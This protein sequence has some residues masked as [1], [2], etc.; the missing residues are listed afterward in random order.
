MKTNRVIIAGSRT[1]PE[2][3]K[4]LKQSVSLILN[5]IDKNDLE[6]VSGGAKGADK[7]GENWANNRNVPVKIFPADWDTWGKSAG[8][9]RNK[10]MAQYANH[11][12]AIVDLE[13]ESRGTRHM[14]DL[15]HR[16]ELKIRII[17]INEDK[18]KYNKIT[19]IKQQ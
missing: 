6:I 17:Y 3:S 18:A 12:I 19:H 15:A 10:Q 4:E 13:V 16:Y 8:Y 2:N 9:K 5:N 11:L 7:F 1:V 14:I